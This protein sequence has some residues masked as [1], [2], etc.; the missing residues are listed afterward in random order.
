MTTRRD[1]LIA[2]G[3]SAFVAPLASFAQQ[4]GKVWRI[5]ILSPGSQPVGASRG[6]YSQVLDA[7]RDLG[8]VEGRNIAIEWRYADEK[9]ERLPGLAA[10]LVKMKVDLI[11][12][13]TAPAIGAAQRATAT[14]PIVMLST[15]DPVA[16]GFATSLARP[17]GNITG[18]T[19]QSGDLDTKRL[20]LMMN[21]LPKVKRLAEIVNPDNPSTMKRVPS[22]QAFAK[23]NGKELLIV[24]V[25]AEGEFAE[26]FSLMARERVGAFLASADTFFVSHAARIA[27]LALQYRL[28]SIFGVR[29]GAEAGALMSYGV[30]SRIQRLRAATYVDR[31]LKGAKPGDLPIEQ[32]T[33]FEMVI[34]LKTARALGIR[35]PDSTLLRADKVIE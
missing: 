8:W 20:D 19:N 27:E 3:A 1:L 35:I 18:M 34:N 2:L 22:L 26:A 10:E 23:K 28:P 32:P 17:G 7:L 30:D 5:G 21:V 12:T 31:I 6:T 33:K 9:Y 25:R 29:E 11:V 15:G 4:Q 16:N 24:K 14:I 13:N